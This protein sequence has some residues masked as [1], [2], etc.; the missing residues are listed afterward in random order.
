MSQ[1]SRRLF[2]AALAAVAA[3]PRA[4][5]LSEED[6]SVKLQALVDNA[7]GASLSHQQLIAEVE[8]ML[9]TT[10]TEEE[11]RRAIAAVSC[12]VCGCQLLG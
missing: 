4:L 8:K 5:A 3:S 11:K 6:A 7:C 2:L 9:D 1:L 12:P 10:L